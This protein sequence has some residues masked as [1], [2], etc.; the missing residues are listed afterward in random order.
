ML[1]TKIIIFTLPDSNQFIQP[2]SLS[3]LLSHDAHYT[4]SSLAGDKTT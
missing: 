4:L 1:N 3:P 2:T